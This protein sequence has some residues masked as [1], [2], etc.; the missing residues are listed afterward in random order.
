MSKEDEPEKTPYRPRETTLM[1]KLDALCREAEDAMALVQDDG[2][3]TGYAE[4]IEIVRKLGRMRSLIRDA[5]TAL[6]PSGSY[7]IVLGEE[8][9]DDPSGRGE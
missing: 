5:E 4:K 6:A 1:A 8:K 3:I 2:R 7:S 9:V